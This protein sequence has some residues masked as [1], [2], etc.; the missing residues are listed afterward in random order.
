DEVHAAL[1]AAGIR[2]LSGMMETIGEDYSTLESIRRTG[3]VA[4]DETWE[5]NLLVAAQCAQIA[6]ALGITLVTFHAGFIPHDADDPRRGE[7]T[8]R[9]RQIARVFASRGVRVALETGQETAETL[10]ELLA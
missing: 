6:E 7:L 1:D 9:V 10:A 8:E 3:G 2:I 4:P 5:A